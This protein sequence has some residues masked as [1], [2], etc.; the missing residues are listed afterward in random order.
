VSNTA[1]FCPCCGQRLADDWAKPA[2]AG[3]PAEPVPPRLS[4][5]R[6]P[7]R[8]ARTSPGPVASLVVRGYANAMYRLGVR[9]EVRHNEGEAVRCYGKASHLGNQPAAARLLEIPLAKRAPRP[10]KPPRAS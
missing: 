9:Y 6:L 2:T 1:R 10:P 3:A 5:W 4:W 7:L 8:A